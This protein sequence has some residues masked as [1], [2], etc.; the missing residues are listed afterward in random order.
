MINVSEV[1]IDPDLAQVFTIMRS[2]G[3]YVN[4]VWQTQT[5]NVQAQGVISIAQEKELDMKPEGDVVLG[6]I[7]V[8]TDQEIFTTQEGK[9]SSDIIVWQ[10]I[11]YRVLKVAQYVDYGY[12]R[13]IATRMSTGA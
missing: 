12:W 4:G 2:S 7:V 3:V 10:G 8:H 6:A 11:Q 9:G 13:A 5:A 1:V